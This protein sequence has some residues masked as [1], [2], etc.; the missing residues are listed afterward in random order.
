MSSMPV[1]D[2]SSNVT[3]Q[4]PVSN[5]NQAQNSQ[6]NNQNQNKGVV[7]TQKLLNGKLDLFN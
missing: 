4:T 5:L 3:Q 7:D 6:V 1:I 2:F